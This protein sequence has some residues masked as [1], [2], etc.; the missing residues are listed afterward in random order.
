MASVDDE[1]RIAALE[2]E[3]ADLRRALAMIQAA[4][5]AALNHEQQLDSS[6]GASPGP[7]R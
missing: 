4:A 1:A 6:H 3:N 2:A 5:D 7:G